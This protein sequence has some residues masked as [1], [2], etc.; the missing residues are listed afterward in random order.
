MGSESRVLLKSSKIHETIGWS[1]NS[2]S[3]LPLFSQKS[4]GERQPFFHGCC[5]SRCD[6]GIEIRGN[7]GQMMLSSSVPNKHGEEEVDG[8][9]NF[10]LEN[11]LEFSTSVFWE[12]DWH[13]AKMHLA[14][15]TAIDPVMILMCF[16]HPA[17]SGMMHLKKRLGRSS[18]R[19]WPRF[20]PYEPP[21]TSG[22]MWHFNR[23]YMGVSINGVSPKW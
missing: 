6:Q 8:K 3:C 13:Q 23:N 19:S 7:I 14:F 20:G 22:H 16:V 18:S 21:G 9:C 11:I 4:H 2:F 5:R 12:T 10:Y 15:G 1:M 17:T